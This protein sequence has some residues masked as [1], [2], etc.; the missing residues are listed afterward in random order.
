MG[1]DGATGLVGALDR[2]APALGLAVAG[3]QGRD[4]LAVEQDGLGVVASAVVV[5]V[6]SGRKSVR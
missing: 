4:D 1:G 2:G 5:L 6:C 3:R